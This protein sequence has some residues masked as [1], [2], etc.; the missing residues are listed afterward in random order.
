MKIEG[1][2]IVSLESVQAVEFIAGFHE[3]LEARPPP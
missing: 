1:E 3:L 2:N